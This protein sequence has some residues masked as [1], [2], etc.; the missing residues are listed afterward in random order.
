MSDVLSFFRKRDDGVELF[1][2]LTPRSSKDAIEGVEQAADERCHLAARVRAVPEK[3][4]ANA[5]LERL[6]AAEFGIPKKSIKVVAGATSRLKTI[7]ITG[8]TGELARLMA[9]LARR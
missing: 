2:R 5:A 9:E 1:V 4:E 3:G 8:N 7:R 6:L